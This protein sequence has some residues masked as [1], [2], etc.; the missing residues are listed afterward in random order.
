MGTTNFTT[1]EGYTISP[2]GVKVPASVLQLEGCRK[3]TP[4]ARRC[5]LAALRGQAAPHSGSGPGSMQAEIGYAFAHASLRILAD[6]LGVEAPAK[7]GT[8]GGTVGWPTHWNMVALNATPEQVAA[9]EDT[10]AAGLGIN[11]EV[12]K[13]TPAPK[14]TQAPI[15]LS[16]APVQDPATVPAKRGPG[17]PRRTAAVVTV[18]QAPEASL[19]PVELDPN[20]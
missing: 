7:V 5:Y 11:S 15:S 8:P 4:L 14:A 13:L 20:S 9:L 12:I 6:M 10:N 17:R 18:A 3:D 19:P 1:A 16:R 2:A